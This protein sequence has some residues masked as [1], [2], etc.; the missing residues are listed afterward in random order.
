ML[1]VKTKL[2]SSNI[3]GIGLFAD[4]PIAKGEVIW[5]FS[6][7]LDLLLSK[8]QVDNLSAPA[9]EQFFN[10]SYLDK[11]RG[12]YLLCGDDSRFFNHS[13]NPNCLDCT[14]DEKDITIA[15]RDIE[16]GEELTC[17]YKVFYGDIEDH[18]EIV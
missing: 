1:C 12:K 9:R 14:S 8:E 2:K 3:S 11:I 18:Q 16:A 10:Y 17:D 5:E 4:E 7:D 15:A 13:D 6:P